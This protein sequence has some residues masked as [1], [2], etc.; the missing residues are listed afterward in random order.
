M[1]LPFRTNEQLGKIVPGATLNEAPA[2]SDDVSCTGYRFYA[3]D[4]SAR[5]PIFHCSHTT[6]VRRNVAANCGGIR[7]WEHRIDE[8]ILPRPFVQFSKSGAWLNDS[9]VTL[10]IDLSDCGHLL[11]RDDEPIS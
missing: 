11:E 7:P 3:E 8:A 1:S 5:N 6:G 2:S 4:M 10:Y 9:D